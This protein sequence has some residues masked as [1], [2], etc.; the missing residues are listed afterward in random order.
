MIV[1][2]LRCGG[3]H[4]FEAWFAS[5]AAFDEQRDR[6]LVA[7]P[8]CGNV[9]IG[10]AVMAPHVAPK[11]NRATAPAANDIDRRAM[12][13]RLAEAQAQL[14]SRSRWVG[15][16]FARE[17]RA[18]HDGDSEHAAIHGQA[19]IAEVTALI[20]DG[21]PVAP[22]PLPVTPPKQLN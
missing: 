10:K 17:A 4:V 21:V 7:C 1:F 3:G 16:D 15:S 9:E 22:L 18:M 14:L 2:D 13:A 20:E 6:K 19:S 5:S 8:L 12:L 11:G